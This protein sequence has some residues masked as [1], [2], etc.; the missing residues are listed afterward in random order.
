MNAKPNEIIPQCLNIIERK[1]SEKEKL[2]EKLIISVKFDEVHIRKHIQ[3][4]NKDQKLVG[5]D[6]KNSGD[7]KTKSDVANQ[8]LVFYVNAVNDSLDLP[9]GYYFINSMNAEEREQLVGKVLK[10]L[11]DCNVCVAGLTFDGFAANKSMCRL[12]GATLNVYSPVFKPYITVNDQKIYIFFDICHMI[13]LVRN[14][15]SA[16]E[17]LIDDKGNEIKWQYFV[18][19]VRMKDSG[20]ALT[21]KMTRAHIDWRRNKMKV[22]LAVQTLSASTANSMELLMN[23]GLPQ[24]AGAGPTIEFTRVWNT[25]FD[26]HNSKNDKKENPFKKM[27]RIENAQVFFQFIDNAVEYIKRLRVIN[28]EGKLVRVCNS[29]INT[30]FNGCIIDMMSLKLLFEEFVQKR[31]LIVS[32]PTYAFQ[33]DQLEI[34]FNKIRSRGGY[35]DNPTCEQFSAAFR[36]LLVYNTVMTSKTA[37]CNES[38]SLENPYSNILSITSQRSTT[39]RHSTGA[40]SQVS[41]EQIEE[42]YD[43]LNDIEAMEMNKPSEDLTDYTVAHIANI[44]ENRIK[45]TKQFSCILC[46]HIFD[47]NREKAHIFDGTKFV[48]RPCYSTFCICKQTDRFLKEELLKGTVNFNVIYHEI[49]QNLNFNALYEESDFSEH[50]DHKIFLIRFVVDEYV[51]IKGTHMAKSITFRERQES[52]RSKLHKLLHYLGQ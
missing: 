23:K 50:F 25:V 38:E 39:D 12:F 46:K 44:I 47:E 2:N 45:S 48:V 15:L 22:D 1:V 42:L 19:L 8:A 9:I 41:E 35:N 31:K 18:D 30:G 52:L 34:F 27:L 6:V 24:F 11:I 49:L 40:Y 33:Q 10:T 16:K 3:W 37:N 21:H 14:R 29:K 5:F 4:S 36:K 28:D 51:K 32:I 26:I 7:G 13:K 17:V 20:F 43:K